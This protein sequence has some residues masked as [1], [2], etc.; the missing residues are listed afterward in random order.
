ME[1]IAKVVGEACNLSV[2]PGNRLRRLTLIVAKACFR[3]SRQA[4]QSVE[5]P[6]MI[7][8]G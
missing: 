8:N 2:I 3:K 4:T 1:P 6:G 5:H 7:E